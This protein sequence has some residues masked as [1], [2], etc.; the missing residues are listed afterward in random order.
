MKPT[1]QRRLELRRE[2]VRLLRTSELVVVQ[3][4]GHTDH[5][6][7]GGGGGGIHE[8]QCTGTRDCVSAG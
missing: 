3:G 7:G 6:C 8:Q 2:T 4:G 5:C 1:K